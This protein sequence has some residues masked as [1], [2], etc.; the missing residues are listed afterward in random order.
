M[1]RE[2]VR[3]TIERVMRYS[4]GVRRSDAHGLIIGR[5]IPNGGGGYEEWRIRCGSGIAGHGDAWWLEPISALTANRGE[6]TRGPFRTARDFE[7]ELRRWNR[8]EGP[9]CDAR[10]G[11]GEAMSGHDE[12]EF[13]GA[14]NGIHKLL[15]RTDGVFARCSGGDVTVLRAQLAE[16]EARAER[17]AQALESLLPPHSGACCT[18]DATGKSIVTETSCNCSAVVKR[19]RAALAS[20]GKP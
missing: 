2:T 16:A 6:A 9:A 1:T 18:F 20:G 8:F 3:K 17:L 12:C 19:A 14:T 4:G 7:K 15:K 13:C 5:V 11:E 10:L